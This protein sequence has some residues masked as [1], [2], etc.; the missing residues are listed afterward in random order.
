M[1]HGEVRGG[2][3]YGLA[4]RAFLFMDDGIP[5]TRLSQV[6]SLLLLAL[7]VFFSCFVII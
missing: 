4:V 5:P 3:Y 6:L 7:N 2:R 1:I